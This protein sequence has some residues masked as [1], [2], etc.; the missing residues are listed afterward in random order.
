[1]DAETARALILDHYAAAGRDE[2]HVAQVY[3]EDAILDFPQG[4]E[5]IRGKAKILAFRTA[6]PARVSIRIRRTVGAGDLWVNEGTVSYDDGP[7]QN[8]VSIWEFRGDKVAHETAY[9]AA[10]WEPPASRAQWVE[11]IP[12]EG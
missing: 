5:R 8:L 3:T 12:D 10:P 1:M 9:V 2:E 4:G 7:P 6:Y 11:P